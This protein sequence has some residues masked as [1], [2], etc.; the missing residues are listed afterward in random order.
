[1]RVW[2]AAINSSSASGA[3]CRA[4]RAGVFTAL[5]VWLIDAEASEPPSF[6]TLALGIRADYAAVEA[7]L[8]TEWSNDPVEG[9]VHRV[10]LIKRQGYGRATFD[11][12]RRRVLAA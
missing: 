2:P 3:R 1:M 11:L 12:L 8:I 9:Q 10:K 6:V 7:A 5:L 4:R